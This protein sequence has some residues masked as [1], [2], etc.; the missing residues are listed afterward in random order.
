[1]CRTL[2]AVLVLVALSPGLLQAQVP[3]VDQV[4]RHFVS[5]LGGANELE[6]IHTM[7]LR[8]TVELPDFKANGT[9]AEYFKYP[10][11]FAAI[12]DIPG[13][14][15]SKLVYDGHEGWQV[16][17]Q[18]ALTPV[19]GADLADIQRRA[20]IHWNLKLHK[21]Y[22][23]LQ[24]KDREVVNGEDSWKLEASL[25]NSTFDFFFSV[26]TGLLIRFDTDQHVPNGTSSVSISDY[27][28]VDNVLFAFGA[29]QT[30]G[31]VKWSRS[32]VQ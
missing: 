7:I 16:D 13:H 2:R 5:A 27:R 18:S 20:N 29:A 24:V 30:A 28:R 21:F 12:T 6:K 4:L 9:T 32:Q 1:M 19:T 10:D 11:H 8:G 17:P 26:K 23:N 22:P 3:N 25:E 15:A 14:G 31:P